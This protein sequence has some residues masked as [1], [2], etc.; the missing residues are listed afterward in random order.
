MKR[1]DFI[2]SIA[3]LIAAP[4]VVGEL[5]IIKVPD[6]SIP[7]KVSV[8]FKV[9]EEMMKDVEYIGYL[10]NNKSSFLWRNC[11]KAG[12]SLSKPFDFKLGYEEDDF[13]RNLKTGVITQNI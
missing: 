12:I 5:D 8:Y 10:F 11:E 4:K 13:P 2:K 3:L 1:S 6:V 9:S 7:N